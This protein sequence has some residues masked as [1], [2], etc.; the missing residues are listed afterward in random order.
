MPATRRLLMS[1][2]R[3][4]NAKYLASLWNL[5]HADDE[6]QLVAAIR[7]RWRTAKVEDAGALTAEIA[8]WQ[9]ALVNFQSVGHMKSWMHPVDPLVGRQEVRVKISQ[10]AN[11]NEVTLYLAAGTA[12]DGSESDLVVWESP[13]LVAPGRPDLL[14]RDVRSVAHILAGHRERFFKAT[15]QAL[16]AVDEVVRSNDEANVSELA[17]KHKVDDDVLTAWLNYLGVGVVGELKLEHLTGRIESSA[18]YEFAKGWGSNATPNLVANSSDQH[19]RIPGNLKPHGVVVH[20]SPT[21][22]VA[23][24]WQSPITDTIKI[25][26]QV[27]HAHPECGNGVTWTL[28]L[29]RGRTR[30]TL[31]N[32]V[33]AG[34][35]P[36]D[37]G[38][39]ENLAVRTG[40]LVSL[41]IGPRD[42]NHSCDLT[43]IELTLASI[44]GQKAWSLAEDV[45]GDVLAGNPHADRQGNAGV[46]HFYTRAVQGGD[47][48]ATIPAGSL[49]ARWQAAASIAEK[50]TLA[51]QVQTLLTGGPPAE[52]D[53]P[54]AQL[55]RQLTSLGG[56]LFAE[57]LA[58]SVA[59]T[60]AAPLA[61][62]AT[63]GLDPRKFG[64][65]DDGS[66]IEP[67][68]LSMRAP[69]V[70]EIKLP[71]D[72]VAD[73]EFIATAVI[74][75]TTAANGAVQ[76]VASLTKPEDLD[77]LRPDAP[78]LAADGTPARKRF[79]QAFADFREWFP[80]ALCYVQIVP[81][82]EVITLT[83]FHREDEPLQRLMLSD[84]ERT[85]LDR[86]WTELHFVSQDAFMR[87]DAFQ[88][89]LEY[90]SQ[91]SDPG[92][93]EQYRKPIYDRAAAYRQELID[94]E[95]RQLEKLIEF[96]AQAYRRPLSEQE[97]AEFRALYKE[98][99]EEELP[100]DEAFRFLMARV[101]VSPAFLYRL[102]QAAPGTEPGPVS[103]WELASRL[104]YFLWSSL[105]DESLRAAAA[106]GN[107]SEP[108]VLL[109]QTHRMLA[110]ARVRRM[111][112]EF[113]CQWLHIYEFDSLDEKSE[114][115][116]PEFA[117][118]RR[119]V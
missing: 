104:S 27:T 55:Y 111:A 119:Y 85:Q 101:F 49:L 107:L 50:Q 114:S 86:L 45:S 91:D 32:G 29:M 78:V 24:G 73:S 30:Q 77:S 10:P 3:G 92:L 23:A 59:S 33:A 42:G 109:S 51:E 14:L 84:E 71:A 113:A 39:I 94:A 16:V 20:P 41:L 66:A 48:G 99:R 12:A 83:L 115:H 116:F 95:P 74:D 80:R 58:E 108:E 21:L 18:G 82:D 28:E 2:A 96:A 19:V 63:F 97:T 76:V 8:R 106:A 69:D 57:A 103:D 62:D 4:L 13:R 90:A 102:E 38:P 112:K 40:D 89:L 25:A 26:G 22:Y 68:S 43:D 31:A 60:S 35:K 46:W 61:A 7:K 93:F 105:P 117:G 98:L 11:G 34:G 75:P 81:V 87:V 47:T 53:H 1:P 79:E 52:P 118:L 65:R 70:L 56:P 54:D 6:S 36:V 9:Q 72:L 5:L 37:F 88:Q 67:A 100:H 64:H 15:A 17:R 110:D 44:D